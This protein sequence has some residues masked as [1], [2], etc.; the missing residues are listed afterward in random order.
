MTI[1]EAWQLKKEGKINKTWDELNEE[2]GKPYASGDVFRK[3]AWNHTDDTEVEIKETQVDPVQ[4]EKEKQLK[5]KE[6]QEYRENLKI[7]AQKDIIAER[8]AECA[9]IVQPYE[10]ERVTVP[11]KNFSTKNTVPVLMLSDIQAGT[12]ISAEAT[13]GL[14]DYNWNSLE[15]QFVK[16]RDGAISI[17]SKQLNE[18]PLLKIY[19]LGDMVEGLGIFPGQQYHC[20][21]D[22]YQQFFGLA[23]LLSKYLQEMLQVFDDIEVYTVP[24]NHGRIGKKGE[25]PHYLNWD[26]FLYRHVQTMMQNFDRIKWNITDAWYQLDTTFETT[27]LLTHGDGIKSWG[28]IPFYGIQRMDARNTK[29]YASKKMFYDLIAMGHFHTPAELPTPTGPIMINGCF[30]GASV[31]ALKDLN[32]ANRPQQT[33]FGIHKDYG[34]IWTFPIYLEV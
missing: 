27:T 21:K 4:I 6:E 8:L 11:H 24:G 31:F 13:G 3:C 1:R 28:G 30:P 5:A 22:V 19:M 33:L 16:L 14:N 20:D 25:T 2:M 17:L 10:I 32:T 26:N 7:T 34:K 15:K 18:T 29:M 12:F 23:E 9:R